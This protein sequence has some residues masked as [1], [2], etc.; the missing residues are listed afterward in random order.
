MENM[1]EK[2]ER[3]KKKK[4]PKA[5]RQKTKRMWPLEKLLYFGHLKKRSPQEG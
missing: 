4:K 1:Y 3:N 5:Q 2:N